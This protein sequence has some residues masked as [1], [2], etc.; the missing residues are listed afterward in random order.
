MIRSELWVELFYLV[1]EVLMAILIDGELWQVDELMPQSLA[2]IAAAVA[3][4]S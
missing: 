4:L 1:K 2:A 3:M